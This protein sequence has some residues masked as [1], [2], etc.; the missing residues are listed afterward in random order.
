M[1]SWMLAELH[2]EDLYINSVC[3]GS[4]DDEV[5]GYRFVTPCRFFA[6][7]DAVVVGLRDLAQNARF[8]SFESD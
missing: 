4:I 3:H 5:V 2:L 7:S 8:G 1:F 6:D